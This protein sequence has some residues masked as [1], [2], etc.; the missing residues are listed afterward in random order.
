MCD[1]LDGSGA[2]D[3]LSL[4]RMCGLKLKGVTLCEVLVQDS[5]GCAITCDLGSQTYLCPSKYLCASSDHLNVR[6]PCDQ[7]SFVR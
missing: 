3:G 4:N 7:P 6:H 2:C 1:G 5:V